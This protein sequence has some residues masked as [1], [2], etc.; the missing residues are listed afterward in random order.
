MRAARGHAP[1]RLD[2]N[3]NAAAGNW[4]SVSRPGFDDCAT[5]TTGAFERAANMPGNA[6]WSY[7]VGSVVGHPEAKSE[8]GEACSAPEGA[9]YSGQP[10]DI[11]LGCDY[12][13]FTD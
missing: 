11:Y 12:I 6:P 5:V 13:R 7:R 10:S 4:E 1:Y 2:F 9:L 3:W 8:S